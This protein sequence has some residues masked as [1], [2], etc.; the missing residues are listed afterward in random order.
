[1]V[2]HQ[3]LWK[4]CN[5]QNGFIF[6]KFRGNKLKT[7]LSCHHGVSK[8]RGTPKWMVKIMENP[9]K[10]HDLGGENPAFSETPS[11]ILT[12]PFGGWSF[13]PPFWGHTSPLPHPVFSAAAV[14]SVLQRL[15]QRRC[16]QLHR[17]G[18]VWAVGPNRWEILDSTDEHRCLNHKSSMLIQ[19][20]KGWAS[21]SRA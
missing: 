4:I 9:M 13:W 2:F 7:T 14:E 15:G 21:F 16:T 18:V 17:F 19:Q 3:P 12:Q 1:M 5:P 20:N 6:P 11:Y 8:N 10:I